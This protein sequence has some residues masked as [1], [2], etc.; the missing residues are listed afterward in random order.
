[1]ANLEVEGIEN[2]LNEIDKMGKVGEKIK[3]VALVKAGEKIKDAIISE[4]PHRTGNL[5]KNI[6]VSKV[7]S[8]DGVDYVEVYPGKDAFYAPFLE[9]GTTK[10]KADSFMSRGYET[11]KEDA[12]RTIEEEIKK[13]L[14][15]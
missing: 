7:K 8:K 3:K 10:M 11:S 2:L 1:M 6:K 14:G 15:L 5:K 9:F 12:E 13:E 4:A